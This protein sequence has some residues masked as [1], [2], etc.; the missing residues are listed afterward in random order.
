MAKAVERATKAPR[1]HLQRRRIDT[2]RS[3]GPLWRT[4][5]RA[6]GPGLVTGASDDDPSGI[7]TYAQAGAKFGFG[8]LWAALLTLPLMAGVQEICD[9]TALAT[10]RDLGEL[11]SRRFG[12]AG[13]IVIGVLLS[14]LVVANTLNI[15]ADLVAVGAGM[16]LLHAG[17]TGLWAATAGLLVTALVMSGSFHLIARVFKVLCLA[18]LAYLGVLFTVRIDWWSVAT[19]TLVP[20]PQISSDYAALLVAVL[21]T[22]ISP[23]LF[24]WQSLHRVEELRD[25]PEGGSR[26][27]SL[28]RRGPKSAQAKLTASRFDVF[29]GMTLSNAVMF[30]IIIGTAV[31]LGAKGQHDIATPDQAARALA[32]IAGRLASLTFSLGFIG[33]GMLAVPVLAGS[34]SGGIAGLLGK[35]AG[36][37]R[38]IKQAPLFYGLVLVGTAGG[39]VMSLVG[40]DPIRLLVLVAVINGVAAAP[41]LLVVM[42]IAGDRSI[43]RDYV[44]GRAARVLGWTAAALM[45]GAAVAMF[46]TGGF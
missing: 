7:A 10:G 19:H 20:H 17:P 39:T 4:Y 2:T 40:L 31:T 27:V 37:S 38:T 23:Y 14:A 22:T 34:G 41:F 1:A 16:H 35:A 45:L 12:A 43:M 8:M 30:S 26:P 33:A 5:V 24:F 32:P 21:G 25:E 9:R 44:N 3:T 6:L 42:L 46:A 13:R 28:A 15:A 36:F 11:A 29:T 18:L